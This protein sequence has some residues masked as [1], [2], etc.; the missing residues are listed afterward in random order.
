VA[1]QGGGEIEQSEA[2]ERYERFKPKEEVK[3]ED[4]WQSK[5]QKNQI[6]SSS[7]EMTSVSQ[8]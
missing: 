4:K 1:I 2:I 3:G 6:S 5:N 8:T 7:G